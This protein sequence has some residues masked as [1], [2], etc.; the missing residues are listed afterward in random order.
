MA[1]E[2]QATLAI[3]LANAV[4]VAV[5]ITILT[6]STLAAPALYALFGTI[7]I[8][9]YGYGPI[10]ALVAGVDELE[11]LALFCIPLLLVWG[12]SLSVGWLAARM[13][14]E[15]TSWRVGQEKATTASKQLAA[16]SVVL[17]TTDA[18][19]SAQDTLMRVSLFLTVAGSV[20]VAR[21]NDVTSVGI[22]RAFNLW[23]GVFA[24]CIGIVG[25]VMLFAYLAWRAFRK[26]N[27]DVKARD[28]LARL[29]A[30]LSIL[31]LGVLLPIVVTQFTDWTW[32]V[33]LVAVIAFHIHAGLAAALILDWMSVRSQQ[34]AQRAFA[35]WR[36]GKVHLAQSPAFFAGLGAAWIHV[37]TLLLGLFAGDCFDGIR[38]INNN[39]SHICNTSYAA[40]GYVFLFIALY[41]VLTAVALLPIARINTWQR[42]IHFIIWIVFAF[43]ATLFAVA[44]LANTW[45]WVWYA[46]VFSILFA[47]LVVVEVLLLWRQRQR[48]QQQS[49][50]N[51]GFQD[52][53]PASGDVESKIRRL[54]RA[55]RIEL[56]LVSSSARK[57][58]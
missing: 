8:T 28:S 54:T 41:A 49:R 48:R 46:I 53:R 25:F 38:G 26:K 44:F 18:V 6:R 43:V 31:L 40:P 33:L 20:L 50:A 42:A 24:L 21:R 23:A 32:W 29:V 1:S 36:N 51:E 13:L 16:D 22:T 17:L 34:S 30:A 37:H 15:L 58:R 45:S 55:D 52:M 39:A 47:S 9:L 57:E 19:A 27:P 10:G 2:L 35:G 56:G 7:N 5:W 14:G 11:L 3:E 4:P 12:T